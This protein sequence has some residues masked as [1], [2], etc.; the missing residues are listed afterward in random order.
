MPKDLAVHSWILITGELIKHRHHKLS[1]KTSLWINQS[2]IPYSVSWY[3]Q[4]CLF[5]LLTQ[6]MSYSMTLFPKIALLKR[7]AWW[8]EQTIF[9]YFMLPALTLFWGFGAL[10][11]QKQNQPVTYCNGLVVPC[12]LPAVYFRQSHFLPKP[13]APWRSE[14]LCCQVYTC[15]SPA[16][17]VL[18]WRFYGSGFSYRF[19]GKKEK[20]VKQRHSHSIGPDLYFF[21]Q[22]CEKLSCAHHSNGMSSQTDARVT[23]SA[24]S[25]ATTVKPMAVWA[26]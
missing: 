10:A 14:P 11:N 9:I 20:A 5:S 15:W 18:S 2:P 17:F 22:A 26:R 23:Y 25:R 4:Y 21:N 8:Q 13:W 19:S 6:A 16:C 1:D 3:L 7:F 12:L 24:G